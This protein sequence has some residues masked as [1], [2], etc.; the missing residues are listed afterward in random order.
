M[1]KQEG[2]FT[3]TI[4]ISV[5]FISRAPKKKYNSFY[6]YFKLLL[7]SSSSCGGCVFFTVQPWKTWL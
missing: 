6:Y 5:V 4:S 2:Q 3:T 7:L 1:E